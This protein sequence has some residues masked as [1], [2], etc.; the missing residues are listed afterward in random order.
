MDSKFDFILD[1]TP[2]KI[3]FHAITAKIVLKA[4][5]LMIVVNRNDDTESQG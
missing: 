4:S 5:W 1:Q 2:D 3:R